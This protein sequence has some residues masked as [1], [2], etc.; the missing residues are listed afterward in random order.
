MKVEVRFYGRLAELG[1]RTRTVEVAE[2]CTLADL[3]R[4]LGGAWPALADRGV[5]ACLDDCLAAD[6]AV[7][8]EGQAVE[9]LPVVSGG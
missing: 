1:G 3:R 2:G 9:F 4:E 8:L 6:D 7:I 5:R